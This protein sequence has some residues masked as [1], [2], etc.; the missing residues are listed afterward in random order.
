VVWAA[1]HGPVPEGHHVH[2][3]DGNRANNAISNLELLHASR[4]LS[5]HNVGRQNPAWVAAAHR[6]AKAWHGSDAGRKW[7]SEHFAKHLAPVFAERAEV[8]CRICGKTYLAAKVCAGRAMYCSGRCR[9]AALR[10]SRKQQ[11][12]GRVLSGGG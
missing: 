7:H 1:S 10:R 4:H 2:H 9:A 12:D 5:E 11:R 3:R 8:V 6:G